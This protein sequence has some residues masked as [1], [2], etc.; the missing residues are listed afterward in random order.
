MALQVIRMKH[1]TVPFSRRDFLQVATGIIG[2]AYSELENFGASSPSNADRATRELKGLGRLFPP[3]MTAFE[4]NKFQA[5]AFPVPVTGIV[6]RQM[7]ASWSQFGADSRP[8]PVSGVPLGGIDTGALNVEGSGAFGYSSI[9]N[10]YT[11]QGGPLNTP[12]LGLGIGGSVWVLTSRRTK[13]YAG[14]CRPSLGPPMTFFET[15]GLNDI[16]GVDYWGHY[17][18]ADT[19]FYADAPVSV[20]AR[21]WAPFI[22]GDSKTSNTPGAIFE[23]HLTNSSPE[24]QSGTLAFSFPG[25]GD[26]RSKNQILGWTDLA[27]KPVLPQPHVERRNAPE[28]ISGTWVQDKG[29]GMSYVL[30]ALEETGVRAGGAMGVDGSKWAQI[31]SA[32]PPTV[33]PDSGDDGGSSLAVDF[34]L[35]PGTEKI[36]RFVLAWYAPE[37]E[38]N[39][40]PG[41]GGK[42]IITRDLANYHDG[43]VD[44]KGGPGTTGKRYTHMYASRFADAG[45]VASFLAQHHSALLKRIIAWQSE[46]YSDKSLPGYLA[47]ALINA[48]YYFGPCSVWAQAKDPVGS[49]CKPEDGV[50]ALAEAPRSCAHMHT[51]QNGAVGGPFLSMFFPTWRSPTFVLFVPPRVPT[52]TFPVCWACGWMSPTRWATR[53]RKS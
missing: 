35:E 22:P 19:Q 40:N 8:R 2:S 26:H 10:H 23:I 31:V 3:D 43:K 49:W 30:G 36:V 4:W 44:P 7:L 5:A 51:M 9:F 32:L 41:T 16:S 21:A 38:G 33:S 27:A 15:P 46:I 34:Y 24:K 13:N 25:F 39:G 14:D 42:V 47:D 20:S 53:I 45:E 48:F 11:P 29:W 17:P 52:A 37:W 1:G 50:F 18:I 28:G 6:Y 12:Y